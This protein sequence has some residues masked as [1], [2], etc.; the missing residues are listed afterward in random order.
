[1][2]PPAAA[3]DGRARRA[4]AWTFCQEA[5]RGDIADLQ[6]GTTGEGVHLGAM[7][8]TPPPAPGQ[9]PGVPADGAGRPLGVRPPKA[10]ARSTRGL[11]GPAREGHVMVRNIAAGIDGSPESLAAAH[12][13][14]Q[15]AL[16]RGVALSLVHAWHPHVRPAPYVPLDSTEHGWAEHLLQEAVDSVRAAHPTLVVA[17]R[18]MCDS[19]VSALLAAAGEAEL[20]VLGSLGLGRTAGFVTGSVSQ[21]VVGRAPCPVVLVR[22]GRSAADEHLPAVDGVAPDEIPETPYRAVVVGLDVTHP[23]DELI[24]FAFEAARRR[25]TELRVVHA[26]KAPSAGTASTPVPGPQRL[27]AAEHALV[28]TLRPWCEKYPEVPVTETVVAGR[29]GAELVRASVGAGL[30]VVGRRTGGGRL[31][32]HTG[33]VTHAVLHHAGCPVAVVPHT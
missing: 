14:A 10:Q 21:R 31:G 13:A 27:A 11:T 18:L 22:A 25:H 16:R 5:L 12:W 2:S 3:A 20:L 15:E 23:C 33:P 24:T 9:V 26:F 4:Q 19:P 1:M 29:A 28:T 8:G 17:G 30:V 32:A 6:G 7:A